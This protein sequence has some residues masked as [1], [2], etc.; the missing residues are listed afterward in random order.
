MSEP[1]PA[2]T[3]FLVGII[4]EARSFQEARDEA[5]R[6]VGEEAQ[7]SHVFGRISPSGNSASMPQVI[8]PRGTLEDPVL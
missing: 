3:R 5:Q 6:I 2:G 8:D 1:F 4:L 7:V